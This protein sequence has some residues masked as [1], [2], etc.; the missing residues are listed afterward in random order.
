MMD[1]S[2]LHLNTQGNTGR[3]EALLNIKDF[4]FALVAETVKNLP[5][6]QEI[7]V[8]YLNQED[9]LEKGMATHSSVLAWRIPGT[10]EPGG[11]QSMGSQRFGQ[12]WT[13]NTFTSAF[14]LG[15]VHIIHGQLCSSRL[16]TFY[17]FVWNLG[18]RRNHHLRSHTGSWLQSYHAMAF[19]VSVQPWQSHAWSFPLAKSCQEGELWPVNIQ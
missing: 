13:T 15:I 5:A 3:W 18:W 4:P 17:F 8:W 10:E 9:P 19:K 7:W 6:M 16:G 2:L 1:D 11:L 14:S 12:D